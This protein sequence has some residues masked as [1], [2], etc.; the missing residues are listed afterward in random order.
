M[1]DDKLVFSYNGGNQLIGA[2][3]A[4]LVEGRRER[5]RAVSSL[6]HVVSR[7]I[8]T[9]TIINSNNDPNEV[10]VVLGLAG[11]VRRATKQGK[12]G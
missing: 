4:V 6:L 10:R 8:A 11:R 3:F 5:L 7:G 12:D 9:G 1:P 2:G